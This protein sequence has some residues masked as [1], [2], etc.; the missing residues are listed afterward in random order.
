TSRS[1]SS[2]AARARS[3]TRSCSIPTSGRSP[4][5]SRR[6]CASSASR[7]TPTWS[8]RCSTTSPCWSWRATPPA[9][10]RASRSSRPPASVPT[11]ARSRSIALM[12]VAVLAGLSLS[13][14]TKT[15]GALAGFAA[16]LGLAVLTALFVAQARE[17]KRLRDWAGAAPE[18]ALEERDAQQAAAGAQRRAA[19]QPRLQTPPGAAPATQAPQ[20]TAPA[21]AATAVAVARKAATVARDA[22]KAVVPG[23]PATEEKPEGAGAVE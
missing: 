10:R 19:Y 20:P 21:P 2:A 9:S 11:P 17:L 15:L 14:H 8:R 23:A 3:S 13:E 22:A 5:R 1:R 16:V 6:S 18:R 4:R 7:S 12:T